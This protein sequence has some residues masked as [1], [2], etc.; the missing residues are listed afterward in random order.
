MM[1]AVSEEG[2][3][4]SRKRRFAVPSAERR[5]VMTMAKPSLFGIRKMPTIMSMTLIDWM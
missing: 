2:G 1:A 3:L 5:R 4:A